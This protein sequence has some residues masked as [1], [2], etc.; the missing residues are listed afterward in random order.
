MIKRVRLVRAAGNGSFLQEMAQ[1]KVVNQVWLMT[2]NEAAHL[3][4]ALN[5]RYAFIEQ[6]LNTFPADLFRE[7]GT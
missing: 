2:R 7:V 1:D 4:V 6:S 3:F 5:E